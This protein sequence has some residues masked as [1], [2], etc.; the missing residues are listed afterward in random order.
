MWKQIKT[1]FEV[2]RMSCENYVS[3]GTEFSEFLKRT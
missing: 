1:I 3:I 2:G